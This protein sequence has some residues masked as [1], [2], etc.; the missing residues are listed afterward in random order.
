M[1]VRYLTAGET[2][3]YLMFQFWLNK[4]IVSQFIES[5]CEAIYNFLGPENIK[6]ALVRKNE[7]TS[8]VGLLRK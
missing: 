2:A 5:F 1:T 8:N 7:I 3:K 4:N 6:K